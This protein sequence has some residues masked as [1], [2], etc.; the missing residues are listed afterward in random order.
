MSKHVRFLT[1][2]DYIII[3]IQK[4]F[5]KDSS[6]DLPQ[7]VLRLLSSDGR[8]KKRSMPSLSLTYDL[9][10]NPGT[11]AISAFLFSVFRVK[12]FLLIFNLSPPNRSHRNR[13]LSSKRVQRRRDRRDFYFLTSSTMPQG[14]KRLQ[15][16]THRIR[17]RAISVSSFDAFC[18]CSSAIEHLSISLLRILTQKNKFIGRD[19]REEGKNLFKFE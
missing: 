7:F 8:E 19:Q 17:F 9:R 18:C 2:P 6:S 11:D 5:S 13:I 15:R 14:R 1:Y 16:L 10:Y 3:A 12:T 4:L